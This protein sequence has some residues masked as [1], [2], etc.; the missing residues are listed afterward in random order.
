M[1]SFSDLSRFLAPIKHKI[2]RLVGTALLTAINSKGEVGFYSAGDRKNPQRVNFDWL[3]ALTDIEHAQPFGFEAHPK[4]GTAKVI[5]VSPDGS[6]SNAFVIMVQDDAFRPDDLVE[7]SSC[8]YD[9]SDGRHT[10]ADGK[11]AIG[12][13]GAAMTSTPP[14]ADTEMLEILD[15]LMVI[16]EGAINLP[17]VASGATLLA[18]VITEIGKLRADLANIK[19]SL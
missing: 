2:F 12:K 8:Q 19:G 18:T 7:G 16:F 17:G 3:G 10:I 9:N 5:I 15:R 1:I 14:I 4:P 6:R 13:K 11:H